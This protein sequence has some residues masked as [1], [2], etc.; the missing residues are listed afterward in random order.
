MKKHTKQSAGALGGKTTLARF[1][2]SHFAQIGRRGAAMTWQRY[3]L[4]PVGSSDF[5][6]V[7]RKT[8]EVKALISGRRP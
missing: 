4:T 5:A 6:M 2:P 3:R 8:G 1:G 7:D